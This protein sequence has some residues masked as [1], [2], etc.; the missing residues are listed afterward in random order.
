MLSPSKQN[1]DD[2]QKTVFCAGREVCAN[3]SP[4][5]RWCQRA[6]FPISP[7]S[8]AHIRQSKSREHLS[9]LHLQAALVDGLVNLLKVL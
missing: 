5:M 3:K 2:T 7:P 8:F 6:L 4:G 9:R 1:R